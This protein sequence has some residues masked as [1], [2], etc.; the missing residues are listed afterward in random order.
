MSTKE[1]LVFEFA[2][3]LDSEG[4]DA[5]FRLSVSK[6]GDMFCYSSC[7][8]QQTPMLGGEAIR[9]TDAHAF[10]GFLAA[11]GSTSC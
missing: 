5:R 1:P 8:L 11:C 7:E 9:G 2:T 6:V 3:M 4:A 10:G